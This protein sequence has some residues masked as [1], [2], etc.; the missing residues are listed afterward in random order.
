[1]VQ[2]F[3]DRVDSF[4]SWSPGIRGLGFGF[5]INGVSRVMMSHRDSWFIHILTFACVHIYIYIYAYIYVFV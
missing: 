2:G 5:K 3:G 1:M 4:K